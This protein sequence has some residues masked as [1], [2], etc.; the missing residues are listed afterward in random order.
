[1]HDKDTFQPAKCAGLTRRHYYVF[2]E[3]SLELS[4]YPQQC[5]STAQLDP[6][7]PAQSHACCSEIG[8]ESI[9]S[10][11]Y[12][13]VQVWPYW[14][15]TYNPDP[16]QPKPLTDEQNW[17]AELSRCPG[18][19]D[20]PEHYTCRPQPQGWSNCWKC[21]P[22]DPFGGGYTAYQAASPFKACQS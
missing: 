2:L 19:E 12:F 17:A 13:L 16:F 20:D 8:V 4:K 5:L 22:K 10:S 7:V 15:Y 11:Q 14:A 21:P 18:F 3:H 1:M 6:T 9:S